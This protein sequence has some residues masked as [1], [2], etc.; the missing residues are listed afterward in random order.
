MMQII[1]N[2]SWSSR[3]LNIP[4]DIALHHRIIPTFFMSSEALATNHLYVL[5]DT[6]I[7]HKHISL[8]HILLNVNLNGKQ[9]HRELGA[10]FF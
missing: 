7:D 8:K 2:L 6:K 3:S 1:N 5:Y 9:K 10:I 4:N